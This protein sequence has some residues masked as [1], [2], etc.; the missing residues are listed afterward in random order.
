[1]IKIEIPLPKQDVV[2]L[3]ILQCRNSSLWYR[4]YIGEVFT[5]FREERT[6]WWVRDRDG[7]SN[8]IEKED[9]EQ[10]YPKDELRISEVISN[11]GEIND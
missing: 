7:Y 9:C 5:P 4:K 6:M 2:Q 3:R 1:M 8:F 10:I 11:K